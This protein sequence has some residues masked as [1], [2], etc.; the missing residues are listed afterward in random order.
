[1]TKK[2]LTIPSL[3]K[4]IV[5]GEMEILSKLIIIEKMNIY[6]NVGD[7]MCIQENL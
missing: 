1:M 6:L 7:I 5:S 2:L 4:L 3:E